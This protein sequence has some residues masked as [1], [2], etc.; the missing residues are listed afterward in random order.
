M[1]LNFFA[2][3][4]GDLTNLKFDLILSPEIRNMF[5]YHKLK[6]VNIIICIFGL[7]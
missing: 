2:H 5:D 4:T 3:S 1:E 7:P 6:V